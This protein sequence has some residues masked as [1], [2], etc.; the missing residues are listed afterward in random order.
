MSLALVGSFDL[1]AQTTKKK[2]KPVH[3]KSPACRTGCKPDTTTP[4]LDSATPEDASLQKE[5]STL[6]RELHQGAPGSYDKLAA[7][8]NK[9]SKSVWGQR[10]ALALGYDDYT[11]ARSPQALV[12]LAKA[13]SDTLLE[14]YT[15][16]WTA[17]TERTLAQKCG[18]G[19]GSRDPLARS[20]QHR[21]QRHC[22]AGLRS[23]H[24]RNRSASGWFRR[25]C[26]LSTAS[27]KPALLLVRARA[28]ES[29]RKLVPA[30]K[31]YQAIYYKF[32][33]SDESKD[34]GLA[35]TRLNKSCAANFRT[36]LP[37]CRISARRAFYD[38]HKWKE[39]RAEYEKLAAMLKDP[40]NPTRQRALVRAAECR[41]H[42]KPFL[43]FSLRSTFPIPKP[44]PNASTLSRKPIA[45]KKTKA[46]CS[47]PSKNAP[48][49]IRSTAGAKN[50]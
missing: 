7:F 47:P 46:R 8:A 18:S 49:N 14:E 5:L 27:S 13:K 3:P 41:Q 35:L 6:A 28:D 37:N 21:N 34:A 43:R 36:P 40:S 44:M 38:A 39:A 20:S 45:P 17:Q 29:I 19:P 23:D 2:K 24:C 48:K 33:L 22:S 25:A 10:A 16:F 9:N 15:L 26:R 42:P 32:P 12:W 4:A 11:K 50:P 1:A 30:A 31:D